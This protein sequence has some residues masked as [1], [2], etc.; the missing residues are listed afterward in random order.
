[1][2]IRC[3][4]EG[5][6]EL[7]YKQSFQRPIKKEQYLRTA[8]TKYHPLTC[9]L[10]Q[11]VLSFTWRLSPACYCRTSRCYVQG[12][13]CFYRR[14]GCGLLRRGRPVSS[15]KGLSGWW[16]EVWGGCSVWDGVRIWPEPGWVLSLAF[17]AGQ[18]SFGVRGR[19]IFPWGVWFWRAA[20]PR[21][22]FPPCDRNYIIQW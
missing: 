8:G 13:Y 21:I 10:Q 17:S 22:C 5:L 11:I 7:S 4:S 2:D 15:R 20:V 12:Y 19:G 3:C 1:M 6:I 16:R 18:T 14:F 9:A